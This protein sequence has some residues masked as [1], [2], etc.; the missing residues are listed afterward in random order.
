MKLSGRILD[1]NAHVITL[2]DPQAMH[3]LEQMGVKKPDIRLSADPAMSLSPSGDE[4][5][6]KIFAD[7]CMESGKDYLCFALRN[8]HGFNDF[9]AYSEAAE[10]AWNKYGMASV[11]FPI[12]QP[13]DM[14]AS[15]EA[16]SKVSTPH[17]IFDINTH[18]DVELTIALMKKMR[19]VCGMR[20]HALVFS[21]AAG[22]PF[23]ATSYDIKVDGFMDYA[24]CADKCCGLGN[25][26]A[27]W[28]CD[29]IDD[30]MAETGSGES[31]RVKLTAAESENEKA[32]RELLA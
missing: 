30:A 32:A 29:A 14:D 2:R 26:T 12:E 6:D 28:L 3:E 10:Y 8:W 13:K 9:S 11:F 15:Y 4:R 7:H 23:I 5:A 16:A 22:V 25:L 24:G 18:D 31:L 27:K 21:A 19:L 20:L 1:K 17:Y